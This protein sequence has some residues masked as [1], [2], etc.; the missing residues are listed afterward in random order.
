[1]AHH[2][3]PTF[4]ALK[5]TAMSRE[6]SHTTI[7]L[8]QYELKDL[9]DNKEA[10]DLETLDLGT[11]WSALRSTPA[12]LS[13][14]EVARRVDI[15]GRNE[16]ETKEINVSSSY[17]GLQRSFLRLI[18]AHPAI[19]LLHVEPSFLGHGGRRHRRY[20]PQQRRRS[21][22]RVRFIL[23]DVVA[24]ADARHTA[25]KTLSASSSCALI[26]LRSFVMCSLCRQA[27][28]QQRHRLLRGTR[29]RQ[30][31]QGAHGFARTQGQGPTRR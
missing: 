9:F 23:R 7:D 27:L 24:N 21:T 31:R 28:H 10:V 6:G 18:T 16:L 26:S 30:R 11:V 13:T 20:C 5:P 19:P 3:A 1:M 22:S 4:I 8:S 2:P 12:G 14:E 25:G 15:F 17:S 29:R